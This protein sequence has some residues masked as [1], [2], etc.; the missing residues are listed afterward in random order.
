MSNWSS[1]DP[2]FSP[3]AKEIVRGE[4]GDFGYVVGEEDSGTVIY[5]H[6][7]IDLWLGVTSAFPNRDKI[8][9]ND[10]TGEPKVLKRRSMDKQTVFVFKY[11]E[12]ESTEKVVND[13]QSFVD[14]INKK[15]DEWIQYCMTHDD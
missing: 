13:I 14:A 7:N 1:F 11:E 2:L 3:A 8:I 12:E 10:S 9:L 6:Q 15:V 5:I 4:Y